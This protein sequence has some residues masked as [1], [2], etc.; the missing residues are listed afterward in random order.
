MATREGHQSTAARI[1]GE[2]DP[3]AG[4][5]EDWRTYR[6][7]LALLPRH[8][9]NVRLAIAVADARIARLSEHG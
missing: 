3:E 9:A 7:G 2:P 6:R 5:L 4:T 1:E 8:D